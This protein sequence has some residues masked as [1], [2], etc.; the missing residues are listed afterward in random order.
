M[1]AL[2][3][4]TV[5]ALGGVAHADM[6]EIQDPPIVAACPHA[7]TWPLVLA[8]F[9]QHGLTPTILGTLDD[10]ILVS[11]TVVKHG[12]IIELQ[13]FAI[14]AR[15]GAA[16]HLGGLLQE[17]GDLAGYTFLRFEH[18][19][20][21]AY[22]FDLA[23]SRPSSTSFDGVT[24]VPAVYRQ[25]LATFC[26]GAGYTCLELVAKC[27]QIAHGQTI[28]AFDGTI[29]VHDHRL[30]LEGAGTAPACSA[31]GEYRF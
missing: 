27:E 6:I 5:L 31:N 25:I 21:H 29:T 13:G 22:R 17:G 1:R 3:V 26:S 11:V 10:A 8:C 12:K 4:M 30:S 14:Y 16:W 15:T 18:V 19:G 24:S 20:A 2:L 7:A 9:E 23:A 28:S